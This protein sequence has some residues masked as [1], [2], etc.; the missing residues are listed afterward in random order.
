SIGTYSGSAPLNPSIT[1]KSVACPIPVNESDPYKSTVT[2]SVLSKIFKSFNSAIKRSAARQGPN[3]WEL[4]GPTP[5]FNISKTEIHSIKIK[6]LVKAKLR[7][8]KRNFFKFLLDVMNVFKAF[9]TLGIMKNLVLCRV[10]Q[11]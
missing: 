1:A 11:I 6:Q 8:N 3:V 9:L 7:K 5:I 2:R 4:E 10:Q